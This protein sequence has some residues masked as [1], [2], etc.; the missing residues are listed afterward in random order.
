MY[1][2]WILFLS[3]LFFVFNC[4][5]QSSNLAEISK[6]FPLNVGNLWVYGDMTTYRDS[7]INKIN[8]QNIY[9]VIRRTDLGNYQMEFEIQYQI[10]SDGVWEIGGKNLEGRQMEAFLGKK[11]GKNL[12]DTNKVYDKDGTYRLKPILLT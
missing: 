4:L 9:T 11:V 6:Y 12:S 8:N 2:I 5:S 3:F 7:V 1:R 10:K